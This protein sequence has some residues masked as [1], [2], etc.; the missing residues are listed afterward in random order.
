MLDKA[1][2]FLD[3]DMPQTLDKQDKLAEQFLIL[4]YT[5]LLG[6]VVFDFLV[7]LVITSYCSCMMTT[8]MMM[9]MMMVD[10]MRRMTMVVALMNYPT[11]QQK[12]CY[13]YRYWNLLHQYFH[14]KLKEY[15]Y[16]YYN[17][18]CMVMNFDQIVKMMMG[19]LSCKYYFHYLY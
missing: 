9:M 6:L 1:G 15:Y 16:M 17:L 2:I 3:E 19:M 7:S 13:Y 12:L 11:S 10:T 18:D 8:M 4:I 5:N 14:N